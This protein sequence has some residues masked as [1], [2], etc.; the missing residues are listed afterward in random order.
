MIVGLD[1]ASDASHTPDAAKQGL[2]GCRELGA[3]SDLDSESRE[4]AIVV[5]SASFGALD[6]ALPLARE[7]GHSQHPQAPHLNQPH[8]S[9]T[10]DGPHLTRRTTASVSSLPLPSRLSRHFSTR[11]SRLSACVLLHF[12][13][14]EIM[15]TRRGSR[16]SRSIRILDLSRW[17]SSW[18]C[19]PH[20]DV[21][22]ASKSK[23]AGV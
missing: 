1:V 23:G 3:R 20:I 14:R 5:V 19:R 15:R 11:S 8:G 2:T 18:R 12:L 22:R 4:G 17:S 10:I 13:M 6:P 7:L 21:R 9:I 16:W